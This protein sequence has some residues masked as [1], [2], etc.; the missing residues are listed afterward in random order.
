MNP[1]RPAS[2]ARHRAV[3]PGENATST[4]SGAAGANPPRA[5]GTASTYG[6]YGLMSKTGVPSTRSRPETRNRAPPAPVISTPSRRASDKPR[7][8]GR[9]KERLAKTPTRSF[10][11][12]LGG[13]TVGLNSPPGGTRCARNTIQRCENPSSPRKASGVPNGGKSST[14]PGTDGAR[15]G[16]R[17]HPELF[18]KWRAHPPDGRDFH[19]PGGCRA[20]AGP[21]LFSMIGPGRAQAGC[22]KGLNLPG[23]AVGYR[24]SGPGLAETSAAKSSASGTSLSSAFSPRLHGIWL[25]L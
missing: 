24:P 11:P 7:R 20:P 16:C 25:P 19:R 10:P 3:A 4:R 12:S 5:S 13:L 17:G 15:P 18:S 1:G 2:M 14:T 22:L 23:T 21:D 9:N 8:F 6:R